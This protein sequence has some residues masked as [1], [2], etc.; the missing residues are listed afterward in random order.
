MHVHPAIVENP[1]AA[2]F[3]STCEM[4][5]PI[6]L[7]VAGSLPRWLRGRMV[8]TGPGLYELPRGHYSH[9]FDG[10]AQLGAIT[11]TGGAITYR[12]RFLQSE[13]YRSAR[14]EGRPVLGEFG[15]KPRRGLVEDLVAHVRPPH[16][17][18]NA[19]V[20][21]VDLGG[22]VIAMTESHRHLEFDP[23]T[24]ET[25]GEV[26]YEDGLAGQLSTPHPQ[27][28]HDRGVLYNLLVRFGRTAAIQIYRQE[29]GSLTRHLIATLERARPSYTHS[30]ASSERFIV[31]TE[32]P[33]VVNPL[34]LRFS[35]RPYID[36]YD[37]RPELET[38]IHI[39]RKDDGQ[40]Q[41]SARTRPQFVFHHVNAVEDSGW[42]HFD[43]IAYPDASI[44]RDLTL[45]SLRR[46]DAVTTGRLVRLS[47]RDDALEQRIDPV[48]LLEQGLELP[49]VHPRYEHRPYRY[50]Y[51]TGN[52]DPS[53]FSDRI[54]KVDLETRTVR[55]FGRPGLYV[56][57]PQLVPAPDG[58]RED[59][60]VVLVIAFDA[61][62]QLGRLLVLNAQTLDEVASAPLPQIVPFHFHGQ[63]L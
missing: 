60:G 46:G 6:E 63:W 55:A 36:R 39:V 25:I 50:I 47:L 24:L 23:E 26:A 53:D 8:H 21:I 14:A 56:N 42:I 35:T 2:G 30:F 3:R 45:A 54:L 15:T 7:P 40:L 19:N 27:I 9:W 51:A 57:E 32:N 12:S 31:L 34:K 10:L 16:A 49:R 20:N 18:D 4:D 11:L 62:E 48:E 59:D 33:L 13:A 17:T 58:A 61:R 22:H 1:S 43:A 44:V 5:S 38:R 29:L 28:D 52:A 37:W 41:A